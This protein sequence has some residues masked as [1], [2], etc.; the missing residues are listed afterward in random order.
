MK[1]KALVPVQFRQAKGKRDFA[2]AGIQRGQEAETPFVVRT[3]V[4]TA[5]SVSAQ[6]GAND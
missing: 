3:L 4:D 2:I 5:S 1:A 6:R